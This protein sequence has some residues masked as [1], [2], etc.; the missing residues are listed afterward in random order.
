LPASAADASLQPTSRQETDM[1]RTPIDP[2]WPW[3]KSFNIT[4]GERV[5]NTLYLSGMLA[6]D[7]DGNLLHPGDMYAQ[8]TKVFANMAEALASEGAGMGDVVKITSYLTDLELYPD[9]KRA[10]TEAFPDG[11]PASTAIGCASLLGEGSVIEI[12]AIAV[13]SNT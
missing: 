7:P 9:F 13:T 2:G 8:T 3:L 11:I 12:D 4:A 6:F 10:R 1:T 5:G